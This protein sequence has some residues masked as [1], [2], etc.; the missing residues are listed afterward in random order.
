MAL[1]SI[2]GLL[3][4]KDH[5]KKSVGNYV[6]FRHDRPSVNHRFEGRRSTLFIAWISKFGELPVVRTCRVRVR[7][8]L[9]CGKNKTPTIAQANQQ[10]KAIDALSFVLTTTVTYLW[11]VYYCFCPWR[12][13]ITGRLPE[14]QLIIYNYAFCSG[15]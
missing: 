5:L 2:F 6:S 14:S 9:R 15:L 3:K 1:Y 10:T 13:T 11:P 12:P 8:F 7:V 4:G